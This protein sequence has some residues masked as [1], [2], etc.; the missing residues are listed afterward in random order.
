MAAD[1]PGPFQRND[2]SPRDRECA[3]LAP[4]RSHDADRSAAGTVVPGSVDTDRLPA[5]VELVKLDLSREWLQGRPVNL[6]SYLKTFPELGTV[7]NVSPELILAE[8]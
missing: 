8:Y 6:E 5:L 4:G 1:L 3:P 7:E 2:A